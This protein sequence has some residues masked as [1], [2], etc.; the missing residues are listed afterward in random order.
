MRRPSENQMHAQPNTSD[1]SQHDLLAIAALADRGAT[2]EEADLARAQI[3]A[4][5]ECAALHADLVSL[6]S[7]AR[8]LPPIAR[9]RDFQLRP[10]DAQRLRPNLIR[11]LFGS[12]GT[13]RD[14]FSRPLAAGLTTLGL[15]GLLLGIL[16][17]TLS[18]GGGLGGGSAA[19]TSAPALAAPAASEA[20][21]GAA[22]A[23]APAPLATG[24]SQR[25]GDLGQHF[26]GDQTAMRPLAAGELEADSDGGGPVMIAGEPNG[27]GAG[28]GEALTALS[29]DSSGASQ[30]IV[31]S[32]TLLIIGLG[33]FALRW[34]SRRFGG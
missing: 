12:F 5:G 4:C 25:A 28:N 2:G 26:T 11:R 22:E 23:P 34:T 3:D 1:H 14:G 29:D 19:A 7:A 13:A 16:P 30:L 27:L 33:L 21:G 31:I 18:L 15:A 10:V 8:Q 20:A 9:P 32:G 24:E 17:G 6:A